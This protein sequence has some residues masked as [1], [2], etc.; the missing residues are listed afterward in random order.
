MSL[1]GLLEGKTVLV[2]GGTQGLGRG[3]ALA[4]AAQ[5]A[6]A[7]AVTGRN[8]GRGR[9][10]EEEL[11][12]AGTPARFLEIDLATVAGARTSVTGAVA[13][14]GRVDVVVN[15]AGTTTRGTL[16]DTSEDLFDSH[17]AINLRAPFF[18]M[19]EAV[20]H[21]RGRGAAGSIL[22]AAFAHRWDRIRINGLNLGWTDTEGEDD[23]QRRFHGAGDDWRRKANA[24]QPMGRLGQVDEIADFA[25]Y[26]ERRGETG[27]TDWFAPSR[28]VRPG[29][30][31][32]ARVALTV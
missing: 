17:I 28:V 29:V 23:I 13:A 25:A 19:Q 21:L 5:G 18:A 27:R 7:V 14:F 20:A 26:P 16:L 3:V 15:A 10:V 4:A 9:A 30:T 11:S 22:N 8:A 2:N 6:A 1:T 12:K 32:S 31:Q 24:S